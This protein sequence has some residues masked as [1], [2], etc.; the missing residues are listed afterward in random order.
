VD[1]I[2]AMVIQVMDVA[3]DLIIMATEDLEA[4]AAAVGG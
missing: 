2:M 3:V 1:V 4:V